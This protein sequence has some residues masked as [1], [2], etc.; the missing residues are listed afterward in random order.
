MARHNSSF[1]GIFCIV[2]IFQSN[3]IL[4]R[5]W[6]QYFAQVYFGNCLKISQV[7]FLSIER[8]Q[9]IL[10]VAA[11]M[12][13][14]SVVCEDKSAPLLPVQQQTAPQAILQSDLPL[15]L[16]I[17]SSPH[18]LSNTT[19]YNA[20]SERSMRGKPQSWFCSS[21]LCHGDTMRSNLNF[22]YLFKIK[23]KPHCC[24]NF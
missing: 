16:S 2:I 1:N 23:R 13:K 8:L 3:G 4:S 12:N 6:N 17:F 15:A 19:V 22:K 14:C 11:K 9:L 7:P 24:K 18:H 20:R 10:Q 21:K 5:I